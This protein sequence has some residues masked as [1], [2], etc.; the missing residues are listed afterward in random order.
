MRW[1]QVMTSVLSTAVLTAAA[2][3]TAQAA[4]C[5]LLKLPTEPAARVQACQPDATEECG[6][7]LWEADLA[8]GEGRDVCPSGTRVVY[9]EW[10]AEAGAF[11][12]ATTAICDEGRDVEL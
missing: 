5:R 7:I 1:S 8:P 6:S 9:R 10:D 2:G 4:C 11:G 3:G 12:P